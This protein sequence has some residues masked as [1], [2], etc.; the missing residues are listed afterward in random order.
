MKSDY[1]GLTPLAINDR[2]SGAA[3]IARLEAERLKTRRSWFL[4]RGKF[5]SPASGDGAT[6]KLAASLFRVG[7]R[8]WSQCTIAQIMQFRSQAGLGPRQYRHRVQARR[9]RCADT[10]KGGEIPY[11]FC[12]FV[13]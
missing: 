12:A 13:H 8:G 6:Q 7:A 3:F 5:S 10:A 2:P 4:S 1:Q 11:I 9:E